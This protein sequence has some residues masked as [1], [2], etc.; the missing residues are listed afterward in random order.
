MN[1]HDGDRIAA[2]LAA[3]LA[4]GASAARVAAV[5]TVLGEGVE[6]TL[7]PVLGPRGV[8]ALFKR[9]VHLTARVHPWLIDM[10]ATIDARALGAALAKQPSGDAAAAGLLCLTTL[11]SLLI[12][13][14]GGSLTDRL[15]HPVW[16]GFPSDTPLQD[17]P[18]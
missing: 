9:A 3:A 1:G 7:T 10:P 4:T 11:D 12:G 18:P 5:I 2:G 8:A 13:L 6:R 16:A 17:I 15:L 14:I